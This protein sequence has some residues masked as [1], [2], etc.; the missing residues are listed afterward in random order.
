MDNALGIMIVLGLSIGAIQMFGS[1]SSTNSNSLG[2]IAS[3][4]ITKG[5]SKQKTKRRKRNKYSK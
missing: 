2:A 1:M 4:S 5:G 3:S